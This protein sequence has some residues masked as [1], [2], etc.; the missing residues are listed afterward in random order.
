[1]SAP[2]A[3]PF[4]W[5][6]L[7][8]DQLKGWACALCGVRLYADRSIGTVITYFAGQAERVELWACAPHC[9]GDEP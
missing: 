9:V 7:N 2:A 5:R 8:G 4:N 1:M 3:A 6:T